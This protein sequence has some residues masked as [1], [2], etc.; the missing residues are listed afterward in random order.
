MSIRDRALTLYELQ[1]FLVNYVNKFTYI[2]SERSPNRDE[3]T[4]SWES[5]FSPTTHV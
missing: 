1:H 5:E 2:L 3:T 4:N